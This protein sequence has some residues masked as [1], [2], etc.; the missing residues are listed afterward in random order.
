MKLGRIIANARHRHGSTL[1]DISDETG[2]CKVSISQIERDEV[3][4]PGFRTVVK[5]ARAL[6]LSLD[7]LAQGGPSS[8]GEK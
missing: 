3:K 7:E 5:I 4:D 8:K 6:N 1:Q 2:V